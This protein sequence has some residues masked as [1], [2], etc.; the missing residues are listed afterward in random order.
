MYHGQMGGKAREESHRL[1]SFLHFHSLDSWVVIA[2]G[3][4]FLFLL[5]YVSYFQQENLS[6]FPC[7][8][9]DIFIN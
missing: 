5:S 2:V 3:D 4:L 7:I 8:I 6:W 1:S 9:M